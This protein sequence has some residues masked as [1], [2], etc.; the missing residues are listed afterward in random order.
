[1]SEN[2]YSLKFTPKASKD[3]EQIY[4]YIS[5]KLFANIA[6]S[7]ALPIKAT[8]I[9]KK[10]SL[11]NSILIGMNKV[12]YAWEGRQLPTGCRFPFEKSNAGVICNYQAIPIKDSFSL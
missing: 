10:E 2:S 6:Y 8:I 5:G 4:I 12:S 7:K 9:K 3:L 1:M 11:L